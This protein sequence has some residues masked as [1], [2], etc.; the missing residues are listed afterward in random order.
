MHDG[1]PIAV[2]GD[3]DVDGATSAALLQRFFAARR[4]AAVASTSPTACSEGYGPN[5]AGAAAAARTRASRVVVTVDCGITAL[6]RRWRRPRD[7]G[8]DV[9]V[10]DHHLAEPRL[11]AGAR[12]GQPQPAR[13]G[14]PRTASSPRSASPSCWC[15]GAQ[16]ARCARPAGTATARPEPD[17]LQWLDLVALGTV[18]DVVPL[19]GL[20][21]AL[22][23][24]GPEGDARS[25]RNPGLAALADVAR[26]SE[27]PGAYHLGFVLGP[28]V[29]AGGR[30][31]QADLGARLLSTDD[32]DEAA[33]LAAGSTAQRASAGR[34]RR[35]VLEQAIARV[36][37]LYGAER[38]SRRRAAGRGRGLASGVIGIVAS[39]LNERYDRPACVDRARR[40]R[41]QG[42]GPLGA[43]ASISAPP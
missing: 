28:R 40:R 25:A 38:R 15:V 23:R 12:G 39:R 3:Y 35:A 33:A 16:P 21:R 22:V 17:L 13:R 42:L 43:A 41:R 9:I 20:N 14:R 27:P 4:R 26:L 2:F 18:C 11:P 37:G 24:A 36:E 6:R 30:V 1:E 19:T 8:L 32:P 31:G 34:S 10:V 29:N 5:A 7:A